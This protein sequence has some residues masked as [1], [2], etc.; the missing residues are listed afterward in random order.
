MNFLCSTS[1]LDIIHK[2]KKRNYC[3][4]KKEKKS[5]EN[6]PLAVAGDKLG[7]VIVDVPLLALL[8]D[9]LF[10]WFCEDDV[11]VV[12]VARTNELW[13]FSVCRLNERASQ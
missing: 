5:W 10:D 7:L 12:V 2:I 13:W 11:V 9:M 8:D 3:G 1:K 6:L 4:W